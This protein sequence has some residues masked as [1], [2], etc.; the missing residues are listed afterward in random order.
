M[1]LKKILKFFLSDLNPFS[2]PRSRSCAPLLS[3]RECKDS[4]FFRPGKLFWKYL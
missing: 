1:F 2:N 4:Y 3:I